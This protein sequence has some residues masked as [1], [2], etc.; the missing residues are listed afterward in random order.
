MTDQIFEKTSR[1]ESSA[2]DLYAWHARPGAF[3]R[4]SPPWQQVRLLAG[5]TGLREGSRV[6]L[7]LK[8]GPFRKIWK[9][10]H[11]NVRPGLGFQDV[12]LEGPFAR[13][14]HTHEFSPVNDTSSELRDRISY[15]LPAGTI[16]NLAGKNFVRG[17]LERVFTYRH[18]TTADDL[19]LFAKF[20][21]L[22]RLKIAVTGSTGFI[23]SALT[24]LLT[25]QGHTVLPMARATSVQNPNL[26]T[27]NTE[28]GVLNPQ[29]L[30]GVDAVVHLAGES[31]SEGR[32]SRTKKH[33]ILTSRRLG[34]TRLVDSLVAL[35][36]PPKVLVSASAIGFYGDRE[37]EILNEQSARGRGFLADV[38]DAWEAAS[39]S[40]SQAGIRVVNPRFG[41]VLSP[42]GG[43]LAKML[44]LFQVGAGGVLG[45]G[46]QWVSWISLDDAIA[47]LLHSIMSPDL[48][49]PVNITSPSP[50]TNRELTR[51][52][53]RVVQRPAVARVPS[54][55][56]KVAFG[57]IAETMLL[58]G[59]RVM[60]NSLAGSAFEFRH[61]E[62]ETALRHVL[63][64]TA[65]KP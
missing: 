33:R 56:A 9:A 2:Q 29:S 31:V 1:I 4:L 58:T 34:T 5:S 30:E 63:G 61:P 65:T 53:A 17:Q 7:E 38:S 54:I 15:Q 18:S 45:S 42:T 26:V 21:D 36:E 47:A 24:H 62:L 10:E 25:T 16:G 43:A 46:K 12:Q 11:R 51:V 50:V 64:R 48:R 49:G 23:G 20:Q 22:P 60:P 28:D 39:Q 55:A 19:R 6:V 59:S 57:E 44:P 40:A 3:P 14:E 41:V 32:W 27:W 8:S 13:W 35:N 52:L 37:D